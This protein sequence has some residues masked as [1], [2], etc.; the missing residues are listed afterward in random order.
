IQTTPHLFEPIGTSDPMAPMLGIEPG[1]QFHYQLPVPKDHP[2]G[3]H[4]YHPHHH[5]ATDVQVSGGMAGLI[6]CRGPIDEVPEIAAA[7]ELFFVIQSIQVNPT[8]NRNHYELEYEAYKPPNQGGYFV[9]TKYT[10]FTVAMDGATGRRDAAGVMWE[11]S[12]GE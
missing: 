1:K 2:S 4:W 8:K 10:M 5:G 7:R 6:V 3:L 11:D 9:D 12:T